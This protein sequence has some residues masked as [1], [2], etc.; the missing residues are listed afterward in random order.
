MGFR[1]DKQQSRYPID[2]NGKKYIQML[3]KEGLKHQILTFG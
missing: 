2:I 3:R 1:V